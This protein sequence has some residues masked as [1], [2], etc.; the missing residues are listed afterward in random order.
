[1]G[2]QMAA[3][4][5]SRPRGALTGDKLSYDSVCLKSFSWAW[6]SVW[7][8]DSFFYDCETPKKGSMRPDFFFWEPAVRQIR[9]N[10]QVGRLQEAS[11]MNAGSLN[12]T[13]ITHPDGDRIPE[14]MA[15]WKQAS[16][17][18]SKTS[19]WRLE[20]HQVLLMTQWT[21]ISRNRVVGIWK[22]KLKAHNVNMPF[23]RPSMG[24]SFYLHPQE[25]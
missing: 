18:T 15:R 2:K 4:K 7:Q 20:Q 22:A 12:V 6:T 16:T 8:Q 1:M 5:I 21:R 19:V 25:E 17:W 9:S 10:S 13:K 3:G 14:V 24:D 11:S 23:G